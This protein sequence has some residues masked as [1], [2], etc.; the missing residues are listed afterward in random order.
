LA[1]CPDP[2]TGWD[3]ET[4]RAVLDETFDLAKARTVDLASVGQVGQVLPALYFPFNLQ[5]DTVSMVL[6][7]PL[8]ETIV[9]LS[10]E[11]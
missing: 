2:A 4:L 3:E 9:K 6:R 8:R 11:G 7:T 1:V 10:E 5:E